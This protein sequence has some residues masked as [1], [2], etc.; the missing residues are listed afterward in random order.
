[1]SRIE[2]E[3]EAD[4]LR[5]KENVYLGMKGAM[6]ARLSSLPGGKDGEVSKGVKKELEMRLAKVGST[7]HPTCLPQ[8]GNRYK[9]SFSI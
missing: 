8:V 6:D 4:W 2:V 3:T 9:K 7:P 5:V 1:M